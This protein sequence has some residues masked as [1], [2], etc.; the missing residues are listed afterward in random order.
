MIKDYFFLAFRNLRKRKL[1]SW[2][3]MLG[4]FIGIA[5]V[6]ALISVTLGLQKSIT[7]QF[8]SMG[9]NKLIIMPGGGF[10]VISTAE[11]LT[12]IDIG[13]VR[14]T[15]GVDKAAELVYNMVLVKFKDEAKQAAVMGL[16]TD[17]TADIMK[18]MEG[19]EAEEGRD[20][21]E[22]D[23]EKA[24]IGYLIAKDKGFF[25]NGV[26][27]R[28]KLVI[29]E[30]EF[31]VV[32]IMKQIGNPSDDAQ[33]YIPLDTAKEIF[34]KT[35]EID[36]IYVQVKQGFEPAHVA[37]NI[38]K[39]LRDV[40]NEEEGE[41]TFSVQTFE[42]LMETFGKILGIVQI[43]LVG[44]AAISLLV[45]GIGIMN[46][47]YTSVLERTKEIGIMKAIGARNMDI[48]SLF[49]FE[50]GLLGIA[51]GAIGVIIGVGISKMVELVA[52][53]SGLGL[54][55]A[56]LPWYLI[57]GALAFSFLIGTI[58]G[59]LPAVRASRLKPVD[60]LRYE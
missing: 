25:E 44:I 34:G 8:E 32:G 54:L 55:K 59:I 7:E 37:E 20:L 16:P 52:L 2:L 22:G 47:M 48:L 21:K 24:I 4:I 49:L 57:A 41:E 5:A 3:T 1:R 18:D 10:G 6:V 14:K 35:D 19:F 50:S 58:S 46:T 33:I 42:Q 29:Q 17:E 9:A 38:K 60:A 15:K 31:K 53:G 45:G 11:K 40:R 23:K 30:R 12:S 39:E 27:L 51:G 43:V 28:D 36:M 56:A 13:A 26:S